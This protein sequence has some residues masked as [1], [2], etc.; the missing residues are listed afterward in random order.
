MIGH[1]ELVARAKR[2]LKNTKKCVVVLSE[3]TAYHL[4]EFPDAVGWLPNG[5]SILVECKT[6]RSDFTRDK[7]KPVHQGHRGL[8]AYRYFMVPPVGR[9]GQT[10]TFPGDTRLPDGWGVIVFSGKRVSV[11]KEATHRDTM[12]EARGHP[13]VRQRRDAELALLVAELRRY[14]SGYRGVDNT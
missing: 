4:N 6:T 1:S 11:A 10:V 14:Q 9:D 3:V 12:V 7:N 8:G 5:E 2:W 13:A